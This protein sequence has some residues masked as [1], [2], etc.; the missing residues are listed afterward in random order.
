MSFPVTFEYLTGLHEPF[1]VNARVTGNWDATGR[2]GEPWTESPMT[3]FTAEDGCP[4]F[5][6]TLGFEEFQVGQAFSW[7]VRVDTRNASNRWGISTEVNRL[8]ESGQFRGFTLANGGQTE[9]YYLTHC[10]RLGANKF[11]RDGVL[12]GIRFAVWAPNAERVELVR[13][14]IVGGYIYEDGRGVQATIPMR[15]GEGGIWFTDPTVDPV[16]ADFALFDHTPYMFR[17]VKDDGT[18][19]YRTDLFSRC[20]I[21]SG[22][23]D[24]A[25]PDQRWSGRREDLNG[26]KSCSV[27]V[28]PERVASEFRQVDAAGRPV[29]PE[30]RWLD[31]EAFW[32]DEFDADRPLPTRLDDL[33]I[34]ELH[35]DG[36][37]V[38]RDPNDRG[39]LDDAVA[40]LDYLA[41]L[42][43][44]CIELLP[45]SEYEG[46]ANWGYATSHYTAIEYAGGGRDQFKHFIKACHQRGI[47]V[48]FD[49]VYNHY[50]PDGERAEWM[51]DSNIHE[52]NIYYWYEGRS[53]D[54]P[55]F[56]NAV[57]S[58]TP[59]QVGF[60]GYVD[61]NSTGYAPRYSE[62]SVRKLFI[63]SAAALVSEFHVDG[64]R[65]DQTTSI[66]AYAALHAD[67]RPANTA[68]GFGVKFLREFTR[69]LQLIKPTVFL[70][71]EDHSGWD[72]VTRSNE[73]GGLGFQAAWYSEYYHHLIGDAQEDSSRARLLRSAGYGDNRELRM[74]WFAGALSH[75]DGGR[76]IYHESHDE[77][78]NSSY[79]YYEGGERRTAHSARTIVVA[80]NGAPLNGDTRRWAEARTRAV[81]GITLM[82]PGTPM[83]F[84]GEEV[85][86]WEPYRYED[87]LAHRQDFVA[88]RAGAG[89]NMFRFYQDLLR[90]RTARPSVR[91]R[92]IEI[93]Y[94]HDANRILAFRRRDG[95]EETLVIASLNNTAFDA[96]RIVDSRIGDASWREM[97]NS[98]ATQYGGWGRVNAGAVPST[99]GSISLRV[100]ANGIV[101]L[102]RVR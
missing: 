32:A 102:E 25:Q 22:R 69:T 65:V 94:T 60:G 40:M 81:A 44:N 36:L 6:V 38:G 74:S 13:G 82:A 14:E 34:Y 20:Q 72:A 59:D 46:W 96:Y 99:S 97:L 28:D 70:T 49:V 21:G 53:T 71:A 98:D 37:G 92:N 30:T 48:L 73:A 12:A 3:P 57:R 66:H 31:V 7:G 19:A 45:F 78:G 51:Y 75:V 42:G 61:N 91:S 33:V 50:T 76:V 89:A 101:V 77:A 84:M 8:D 87:F 18:V 62:E 79:Q 26:G 4:A 100:P 27:V 67:G 85:G 15:K 63:S 64:F 43:V 55:Q 11:F 56:D 1:I 47:A 58:A 24:P 35:V 17:I 93:I 41:D 16:L 95:L 80:V 39:R 90:T 29:W 88:L 9:R 68:R 54:Y 2:R 23:V 86:A 10:R 52:R 5:R 83:F